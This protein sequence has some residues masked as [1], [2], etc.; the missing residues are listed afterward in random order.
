MNE[1]PPQTSA[2]ATDALVPEPVIFLG[3]I[4]SKYYHSW[5]PVPKFVSVQCTIFSRKEH[6][7]TK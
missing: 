7:V 3:Q 5:N 6:A 4:V 2:S 1:S